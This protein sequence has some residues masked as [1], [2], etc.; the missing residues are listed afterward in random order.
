MKAVH[1][2]LLGR[3][4][5]A[6]APTTAT[7]RDLS[8]Q[9]DQLAAISDSRTASRA[10]SLRA[11]IADFS[12]NVTFVGQ[13]KAGKSK[14][15][16]VMAGWPGLLPSDVNPWTSVVTTLTLNGRSE[17]PAGEAAKG[18]ARFTFF[19]RSEWD[20]LIQGGGRLGELAERAGA[21]D[22]MA[23]I[24]LQIEA[25]REKTKARLGSHFELLLGQ[26][27]SYGYI[28]AELVERYV[29]MGDDIDLMEPGAKTGRFADITKTA[30]FALPVPEYDFSIKLCDTPG[31][32]DTFMMREQIT[33]RSLRGS[34]LCVVVLSAHQALTT[35]DIALMRIIA[36]L[37]SRQIILFVNRVDELTDP[38]AQVDE[39]RHGILATLKKFNVASDVAVIF[40]SAIWAEAALLGEKT[41]LSQ[42]SVAAL[43]SY[44]DAHPELTEEDG[45][46]TVWNLSGVPALLEAIGHRVNEGAGKRFVERMRRNALNLATEA[47]ASVSVQ[48]RAPAQAQALPGLQGG[49]S[50]TDAVSSL[51]RT[52]EAETAKLCSALA[53]DL[54]SR[55]D[56]AE[57]GFVKRATDSL[58]HFLG[59]YGEQ[60]T[61]QYDPTGL[62][63]LQRSAYLSF[64]RSLTAKC[65]ALYSEAAGH[66]E[67]IYMALMGPG[68]GSV[69][70]APPLVPQV[71]PPVSLGKTIALDLQS[72]WW[73]RW[74]QK[75]HG[76]EAY[77]KDYARLIQTET[78]S[79]TTELQEGQVA[80]VLGQVQ[81]TLR[82]FL[83]DHLESIRQMTQ[84]DP[85]RQRQHRP[86]LRH[87]WQIA[88]HMLCLVKF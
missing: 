50:A 52:Y 17:A 4:N 57:T 55:L 28:D 82:D 84:A 65:G 40:G 16:N 9:L 71:P 49:M 39:I 86:I 88:I 51:I 81:S 24:R 79:M 35:V 45:W 36:N 13:V 31:V 60:G 37:E 85:P 25:M 72:T 70:I 67:A 62:R 34:E 47:R 63:V 32:N 18:T 48:Q 64:S 44:A 56:A 7:L 19:S 43:E 20:N 38:A 77:A 2:D 58:I 1:S 10:R 6:F 78:H 5:T 27:H 75:R 69:Q 76:Y 66:V 3:A 29:C 30:D 68:A 73:R 15:A 11:K 33:M 87:R 59:Q 41:L 22:E 42:D 53:A 23:A 12:P 46:A 21:Q 83:S 14:L 80:L 26:E 8:R 74:W 54:N 61:W